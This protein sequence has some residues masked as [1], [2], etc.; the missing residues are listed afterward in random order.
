MFQ[1]MPKSNVYGKKELRVVTLGT[2]LTGSKTFDL[3]SYEGYEN[4]ELNKNIFVEVVG[5]TQGAR[6]AGSGLNVT[7]IIIASTD[8]H[9]KTYD[10]NTGILTVNGSSPWSRATVNS[11][12]G[13]WEIY[14]SSHGA[15]YTYNVYLVY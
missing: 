15:Y 7:S 14:G 4:F 5:N 1:D 6:S 3:T 8:T 11:S 12:S 9:N 13:Y 2:G 10:P